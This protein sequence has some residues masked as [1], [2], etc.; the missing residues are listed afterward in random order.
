MVIVCLL[1][2]QFLK[3]FLYGLCF[4]GTAT[5]LQRS[6]L[7]PCNI[8]YMGTVSKNNKTWHVLIFGY[9]VSLSSK[10]NEEEEKR[11]PETWRKYYYQNLICLL[12][13]CVIG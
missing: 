8:V 12:L 13:V 11:G 9:S 10:R 7:P 6:V 1:L 3:L 5:L 4:L 2:N